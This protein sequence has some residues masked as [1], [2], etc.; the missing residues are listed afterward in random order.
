MESDLEQ[1]DPGGRIYNN[2]RHNSR[3]TSSRQNGGRR[4]TFARNLAA[5]RI[6]RLIDR[7]QLRIASS[8]IPPLEAAGGAIARASMIA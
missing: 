7:T 2:Q 3:F 5:A 6:P 4:H 8:G 1:N